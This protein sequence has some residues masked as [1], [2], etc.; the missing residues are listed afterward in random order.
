M[1]KHLSNQSVI[2][3]VPPD[4]YQKGVKENPLQRFWH[5][6][7][8]AHVLK[9]IDSPEKVLD[10]GCASGWFLYQIKKKH[11]H[12][13]CHGIDIYKEGIIYGK[14]RYPSLYLK[15]ADAHVLP[16]KDATFDCVVCTEVLEHVEK[17]KETVLEIKRVLKPGG[18]VVIELDSGSVLFSIVW[19]LWK[20]TRGRVW[21]DSHLHSF[22]IEKL[23]RL[24]IKSG[25]KIQSKKRFNLGMAMVFA[26]VKEK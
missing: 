8:L 19:Y 7:K 13:K 4:Y 25:F 12:A 5:T 2:D 9:H 18:V 17:P 16:F 26:A 24:L 1:H 23:E 11:P 15:V 14:K 6:R 20:K 22:T 10:V 3:Q 21:N